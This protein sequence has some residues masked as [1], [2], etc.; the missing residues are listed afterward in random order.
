MIERLLAAT[1]LL[2]DAAYDS[3][4]FRQLL[5]NQNTIAVIKP[6]PTRK[7]KVAFDKGRYKARNTIERAFSHIKD[8]RRIATRYDKLAR[9]FHASVAIAAIIQWWA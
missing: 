8:W 3:D 7:R 5:A 1:Y 4:A 6:N 9:N 2:A